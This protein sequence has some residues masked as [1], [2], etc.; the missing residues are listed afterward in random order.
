MENVT[1]ERVFPV[2]NTQ[3]AELGYNRT[4]VAS[5]SKR[6]FKPFHLHRVSS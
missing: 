4:R 6:V 5:R 3:T 1:G 2:V